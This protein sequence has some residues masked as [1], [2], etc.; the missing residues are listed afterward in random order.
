M[1]TIDPNSQDTQLMNTKVTGQRWLKAFLEVGK[2]RLQSPGWWH[3]LPTV[4]EMSCNRL[5]ATPIINVGQMDQMAKM[6]KNPNL[7]WGG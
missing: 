4:Y 3:R 2:R 1:K 7:F 6:C 5:L